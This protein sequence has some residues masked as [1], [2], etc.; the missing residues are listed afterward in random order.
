MTRAF[1]W[2]W[3][4]VM[5]LYDAPVRFV[6]YIELDDHKNDQVFKQPAPRQAGSQPMIACTT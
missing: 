2:K 1:I 6:A 4:V 5:H 3:E